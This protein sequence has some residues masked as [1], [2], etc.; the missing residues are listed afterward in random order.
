V[1][2]PSHLDRVR[3]LVPP[4]AVVEAA[5]AS[6]V[7]TAPGVFGGL[8][9]H[10]PVRLYGVDSGFFYLPAA[11]AL[12]FGDDHP[13]SLLD[14]AATIAIGHGH[15]AIMD[16]VLDAWTIAV[17]LIPAAQIMLAQY[18]SRMEARYGGDLDV[19][20]VH[21]R[22]YLPYAE[23]ALAEH[24]Q[25][26]TL[27]RLTDPD[28]AVLGEKS[29]PACTPLRAVLTRAGLADRAALVEAAFLEFAGALQLLDDL[30]DMRADYA[31]GLSSIPLNL[32]LFHSMGL[33]AWPDPGH[34]GPDDL[35]A[36]AVMSRTEHACLGLAADRLASALVKCRGLGVDPLT[37][38]V[39]AR[40]ADT[41][42]R[43]ERRRATSTP[44]LR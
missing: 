7:N 34:I 1:T 3:A 40:L 5:E 21:D 32:M 36:L 42:S 12:H 9:G 44:A 13:A 29:R 24:R 4:E 6:L 20:A 39:A 23:A 26:R 30:D 37:E 17:P 41:R 11:V 15:F 18:L 25:R 2:V 14:L 33:R 16:R 10:D 27:R 8:V 28:L 35:H 31:D 19:R 38:A 22:D 43:L